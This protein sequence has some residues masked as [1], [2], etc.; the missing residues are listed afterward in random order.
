M[1][2]PI[3]ITSGD[4]AGVGPELIAQWMREHPDWQDRVCLIGPQSWLSQCDYHHAKAV[5]ENDF[6]TKPGQPTQEGAGIARLALEEAAYGCRQGRYRAVVTGPVSKTWMDKAGWGYP[7]QTEFFADRWYGRPSMAFAGGKMRVVLATWHI[8]LSEVP[9]NLNHETL[10][11]AIA[12]A[13][14]FAERLGAGPQ[15]RIGVCGLNP[16]AGEGGLL[17]YEEQGIIDPIL[18]ILREHFNGLSSCQPGDTL[19]WRHMQ[20]EFDVVVAL[21]HD[22][23]L[24]PLK[25]VDFETSVN[26][27]LGLP[28]VRTSPDHGT[29]FA[30]AGKGIAKP[31]SLAN[32]I[33]LADR[34]SPL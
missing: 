20:G 31:T 13:A 17:G 33:T 27:T 18:D 8:P 2:L 4:P 16:H 1:S 9:Q 15:P 34:L 14:H 11:H 7:G 10:K 30:I 5:G 32:A 28:F 19:F 25:S 3:A 12:N 23:G 6:G 21:Y 29:A 24:A 26:V 22:Q